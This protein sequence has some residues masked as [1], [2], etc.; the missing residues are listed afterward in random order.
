[1]SF[2]SEARALTIRFALARHRG[3]TWKGQAPAPHDG[4]QLEDR[5]AESKLTGQGV[6][7]AG[8]AGLRIEALVLLRTLDRPT[9]FIPPPCPP[10]FQCAA[11][12]LPEQASEQA[13]LVGMPL[14]W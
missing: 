1:V 3:S 14:V 5:A 7:A 13:A 6:P 4:F 9:F 10:P 12:V 8:D 2:R 11:T